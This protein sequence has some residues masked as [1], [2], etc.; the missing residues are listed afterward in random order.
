MPI[1]LTDLI[2]KLPSDTPDRVKAAKERFNNKIRESLRRETRL[3]LHRRQDDLVGGR[4]E[5]ISVP[6][7][8]QPG[9]PEGLQPLER[10]TIDDQHRLAVLLSPIAR[11]WL[12]FGIR[13][14]PLPKK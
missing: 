5:M 11:P 9:L 8:I 12:L 2:K 4:D 10:Q 7:T 3:G 6:I 13:V 14:K 1:L